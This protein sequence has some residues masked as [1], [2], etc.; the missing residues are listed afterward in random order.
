MTST[1]SLRPVKRLYRL[2]RAERRDIF[3]IYF[4][5][6]I[7]GLISLSL[8]LGIQAIINYVQTAQV[9]TSWVVLVTLVTIGIAVQGFLQIMQL[10]ITEMIQQRIFVNSAFEFAFR[11]PRLDLDHMH[12]HYAPELV[13]RFFDT[14]TLQ[15]GMSKIVL[16]LSASSLQIV[17]GLILLSLYHP[18]FIIFGIFLVAVL[19][20]V[21]RFTSSAGLKTSITESKYKFAVAHWLEEI[22]RSVELFKVAG[23]PGLPIERTDGLIQ[24]YLTARNK[25]FRILV[26]KYGFLIAFKVLIIG[27][28]LVLGSLL[29]INGQMNIGQFVAVEI[30][31]IML[32]SSVEKLILSIETVYD[33]LT[34]L[35][36]IGFVTDLPLERDNGE[37]VK[38]GSKLAIQVR[39]L[40][41]SYPETSRPAVQANDFTAAP[42]EKICITGGDEIGKT[43]F[44]RLLAGFYG[45]YEGNISFDNVPLG[46]IELASLRKCIGGFVDVRDVFDGTLRDNIA[47]GNPDITMERIV[48][49]AKL[50]G[51]MGFVE[52]HPEGL[53]YRITPEPEKIP[54]IVLRKVVLARA[55]VL[56]AKVLLLE[57]PFQ[58]F[59]LKERERILAYLLYQLEGVTVIVATETTEVAERFDKTYQMEEGVLTLIA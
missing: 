41:F 38:P 25:H 2:L 34:G 31:I 8:P 14:L 11:I 53:F 52:S 27:A 51:L 9:S 4:Y 3:Y 48:E 36:K 44:L 1:E 42:G 19:A 55:L 17:F 37:A 6:I 5:A 22:A 24:N 45:Q 32:M 7:T 12:R 20:L 33:V 56:P 29:V 49:V 43:A 16:D 57:D 10:S 15:K 30:V 46:N 28:L 58:G 23:N 21:V 47:L 35:D 40:R 18:F 54:E 59:T 13:N 50:V 26:S 39:N